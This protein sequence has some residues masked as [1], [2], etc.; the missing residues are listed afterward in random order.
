MVKLQRKLGL[1]L[2]R[3]TGNLCSSFLIYL[4]LSIYAAH[5][6]YLCVVSWRIPLQNQFP[7]VGKISAAISLFK[8]LN[9][10]FKGPGE[11]LVVDYGGV[12]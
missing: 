10:P 3:D 12:L 9:W 6:N 11:G 2:F 4:S 5:T 8:I 1:L 7:E